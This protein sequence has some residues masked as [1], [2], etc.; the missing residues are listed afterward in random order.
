MANVAE[1]ETKNQIKENEEMV[2]ERDYNAEVNTLEAEMG[3]CIDRR[4]IVNGMI[5]A[6]KLVRE[7]HHKSSSSDEADENID[8]VYTYLKDWSEHE[9][10]ELV[11][12]SAEQDKVIVQ[13]R[14]SL[15]MV[16]R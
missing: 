4:D 13:Q 7:L 1:Y 6:T 3:K 12:L 8:W 14:R 16:M 10:T 15:G 5:A 9:S 11:R 2:V